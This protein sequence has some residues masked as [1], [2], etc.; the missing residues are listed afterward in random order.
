MGA[1]ESD[2]T[3]GLFYK[4]GETQVAIYVLN[5]KVLKTFEETFKPNA[6]N[7][8]E[9]KLKDAKKAAI[10]KIDAKHEQIRH[11]HGLNTKSSGHGGTTKPSQDCAE[12]T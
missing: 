6:K 8:L 1:E 7:L 10:Y 5:K 11:V 4:Y 2:V 9:T 12:R 3:A